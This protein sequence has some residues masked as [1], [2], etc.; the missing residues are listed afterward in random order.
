MSQLFSGLSQDFSRLLKD[1]DDY[2]VII[3]VGEGS[4]MKKFH[5]HSVILRARSPYFHSAL[6]SEWSRKENGCIVFK[7]LGVLPSIFRILIKYIYSGTIILDEHQGNDLFEILA[8]ADQF[9]L[10]ELLEY[11]Q[12]YIIQNRPDW[13]K[14]NLVKILHSAVKQK[15]YQKLQ[16]FCNKL[17]T[18]NARIL[19]EAKDFNSVSE[20]VLVSVLQRDDLGLQ[21][22]EIWNKV[23]QWGI[24]NTSNLKGNVTSWN[25]EDFMFLERTMHRV[26]PLLRLFQMSP[27]D[28]CHKVRPY[29]QLFPKN[30]QEDLLCYYLANDQ[31]KSANILP[32]RVSP[33]KIDSTI[34]GPQH[35]AL[36]ARWLDN[37]PTI[38]HGIQYNFTLL[39][40]ASRD[41]YS[42]NAL[43]QQCACKGPTILVLKL[44]DSGQLIGGYN[45]IG[46]K[47]VKFGRG[48]GTTESFIF[49]LGDGTSPYDAR[50]S[51]IAYDNCD[52]EIDDLIWIGPKFGKG[53]DLWVRMNADQSGEARKGTYESSILETEGRF[54][55]IECEIFSLMKK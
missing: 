32:P 47:S 29:K 34:I 1:A 28:Y 24:A 15:S 44:R 23:I 30:L 55:W 53:P 37:E 17:I 22:V 16:N 31:P 26:I 40:R 50:I 35:T 11:L 3:E 25:K 38:R 5:A 4:N 8:A 39:F 13:I 10:Y 49:T 51:R 43:K 9:L 41:G 21:E 19:F 54:R 46:W 7:Q 36:I 48:R 27:A 6:S 42:I 45:P 18:E 2:N 20:N 52:T 33:I 12:F 14:R